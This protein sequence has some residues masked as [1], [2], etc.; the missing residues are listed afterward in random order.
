MA[1]ASKCRS[2]PTRCIGLPRRASPHT[3]HTKRAV[4]VWR[5][6]SASPGSA[7]LWSGNHCTGARVNGRLVPLRYQLQ[8]GDTIEIITT[9]QQTPGKDWLKIV[10][11]SKAQARIRQW[12]KAQQR[13]RS[14]ALGREL[15]ERELARYHLDLAALRKQDTL[16]AALKALS[17][18]DEE[19]LLAAIG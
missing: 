5:T 3:G 17:L 9:P 10:K 7:N 1:S 15:L 2:V 18:K 19:T 13:E 8:N 11:T 16:D 4:V 12:I 6:P 14:V